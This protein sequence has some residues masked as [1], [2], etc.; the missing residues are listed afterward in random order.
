[1]KKSQ[2]FKKLAPW[3]LLISWALVAGFVLTLVL[4]SQISFKMLKG[5]DCYSQRFLDL[6]QVKNVACGTLE[7]GYPLR[8]L[9]VNEGVAAT[10]G[11]NQVLSV[12]GEPK[13]KVSPL[14]ADIAI[15]SG[16]SFAVLWLA[17]FGVRYRR[18]LV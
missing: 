14:V 1:M 12:A 16:V 9:G 7:R 2:R 8:F 18:R 5:S 11:S 13:V 17:W 10:G 3:A 6:P 4:T 15:W